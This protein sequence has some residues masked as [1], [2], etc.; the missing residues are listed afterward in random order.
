L[1]D[2]LEHKTGPKPGLVTSYVWLGAKILSKKRA[3]KV[4]EIDGSC[5]LFFKTDHLF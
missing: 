3:K 4:D 2:Q 5:A 1:G